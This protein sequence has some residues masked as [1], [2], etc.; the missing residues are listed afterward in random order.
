MRTLTTHKINAANDKLLVD[1][2]DEPGQGGANHRYQ[3]SGYDTST[4]ASIAGEQPSYKTVILFQ[5]GPI[6]EVGVNGLTHEALLAICID[7]LQ[8][9]QKGP[10]ACRENALALT[11]LEEAL[12]WL[13]HRTLARIA[14]GVEGTHQQ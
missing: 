10:F 11:K 9:F 1:V 3:I 2:H 12:H 14:R 13:Q 6:G 8:S 4:N 5:N 7:R